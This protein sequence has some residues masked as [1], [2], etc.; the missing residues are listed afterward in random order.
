MLLLGRELFPEMIFCTWKITYIV[1]QTWCYISSS[2][3][4]SLLTFHHHLHLEPQT[5]IFSSAQE[6]MYVFIIWPHF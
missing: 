1:G 3:L 6:G 2:H 5:S 4:S